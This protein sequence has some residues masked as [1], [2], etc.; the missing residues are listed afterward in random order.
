MVFGCFACMAEKLRFRLVQ[1]RLRY[2][3][4][5]CLYVYTS[6]GSFLFFL[7]VYTYWCSF[8]VLREIPKVPF[9]TRRMKCF[10][11][12]LSSDL[13]G[14]WLFRM[15]G[16]KAAFWACPGSVAPYFGSM[17]V[18]RSWGFLLVFSGGCYV[19][20]LFSCS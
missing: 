2:V 1:A 6:W 15:H 19:L 11:L 7:G 12:W 5:L 10:L 18:Y 14:V 17:S 20:G 3:L 16:G 4:D 8:L 13:G 9:W